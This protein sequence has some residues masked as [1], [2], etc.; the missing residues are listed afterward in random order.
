M[1]AIIPGK[2]PGSPSV[3]SKESVVELQSVRFA[4]TCELALWCRLLRD[5][6]W[7]GPHIARE[8]GRSEGYVNN[9]I[10]ILER[11][12]IAV[13]LRWKAEQEPTSGLRHVCATDWMMQMCLLPHE[14]QDEELARRIARFASPVTNP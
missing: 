12:S 13:L 5:R 2:K 8:L 7:T 4:G 14:Q 6:G 1:T 3:C 11:A 10:R 9:L